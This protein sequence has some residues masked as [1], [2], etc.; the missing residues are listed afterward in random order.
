MKNYISCKKKDGKYY[1][2][3]VPEEIRTYI[4]QLE[5]YINNPTESKLLEIYPERFNNNMEKIS[6]EDLVEMTNAVNELIDR[7]KTLGDKVKFIME[8]SV[9]DQAVIQL[10]NRVIGD[11]KPLVRA[12]MFRLQDL[13]EESAKDAQ[14]TDVAKNATTKQT[15]KECTGYCGN[16]AKCEC[17]PTD[18]QEKIEEI[19]SEFGNKFFLSDGMLYQRDE[20]G[21][22]DGCFMKDIESWLRD[23]LNKL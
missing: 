13:W 11:G 16:D 14:S 19:I 5:C 23:K 1:T 15:N 2:F 9:P 12:R 20:M 7:L 6:G 18:K 17:E 8:N 22:A 10:A 3:N 4:I 21:Y